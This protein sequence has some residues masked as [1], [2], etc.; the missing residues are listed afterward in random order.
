VDRQVKVRGFRIELGEIEA[1]LAEHEAVQEAVVVE[2]EDTPGDKNLVAY[3]VAS[4]EAALKAADDDESRNQSV[5]NW[6]E[7]F[8]ETYRQGVE[9]A[10]PS[11][12]ITGWNSSY[13]GEA[14][15][16]EEMREWVEDTVAQIRK[17]RPRRVLELGCG[18]GLL[19]FRWQVSVST[20]AA[21]TSR[22]WRSISLSNTS[23]NVSGR[24]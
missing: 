2:R 12:N 3:V 20:T 8:D 4:A 23:V 21:L 22:K 1:A 13:T 15:P 9:V 5:S 6:E 7:V 17:L 16:A 18:T 14:I 24:M 19:L 11:F 10:D